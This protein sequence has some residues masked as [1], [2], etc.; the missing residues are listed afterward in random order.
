MSV[1]ASELGQCCAAF[2]MADSYHIPTAVF[3]S[4]W[5]IQVRALFTV[6]PRLRQRVCASCH[7]CIFA[8]GTCSLKAE[9]WICS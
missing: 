5:K 8:V 6:R 4:C 9:D 2:H 7:C 1:A 3:D